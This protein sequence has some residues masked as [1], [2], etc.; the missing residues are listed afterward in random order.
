MQEDK[1]MSLSKSETETH[2]SWTLD[3]KEATLY[4]NNPVWMRKM[5]KLCHLRS[6]I[7]VSRQDE[8]SKTYKF[9]F[10]WVKV[11]PPRVLS[12]EKRKELAERARRNFGK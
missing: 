2:I 5:D 7:T 6:E 4:T 1:A 10:K 8:I 11:V 12:D 9:P 3:E